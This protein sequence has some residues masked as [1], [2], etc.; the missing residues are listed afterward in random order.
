MINAM[1][2]I[3]IVNFPFLDGDI[4]R[5][6]SYRVYISQLSR[7]AIVPSQV[8]HSKILTVKLLKAISITNFLKLFQNSIDAT[9]TWY[10]N[11]I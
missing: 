3:L 1:I 10:Q 4:P 9:M 7:F 6:P 5:A 2:L 8:K 11:L